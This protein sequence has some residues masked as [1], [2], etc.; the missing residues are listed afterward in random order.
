MSRYVVV[1]V[2]QEDIEKGDRQNESS[3]PVARAVR[4]TGFP[5]AQ[6]GAISWKPT[7]TETYHANPLPKSVRRFIERFD[8]GKPVS[9]AR[10]RLAVPE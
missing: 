10:F 2:T 8:H 6:V 9:P 5:D 7:L 1:E 3:C 4:R